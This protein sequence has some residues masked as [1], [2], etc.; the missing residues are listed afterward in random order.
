MKDLYVWEML[1]GRSA[2]DWDQIKHNQNLII[3]NRIDI[4]Q[5]ENKPQ[6]K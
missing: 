4:K 5:T 6:V 3:K 2:S 1:N